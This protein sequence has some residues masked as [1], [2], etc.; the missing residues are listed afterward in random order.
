M[1]KID[2]RS[3][4][5][6]LTDVRAAPVWQF[7]VIM[8]D[9]TVERQEGTL[10]GWAAFFHIRVLCHER[11]SQKEQRYSGCKEY[12]WSIRRRFSD[13][14]ELDAALRADHI[15][16]P[17]I[18][19]PRKTLWRHLYPSQEFVEQRADELLKFM[20]S[21]LQAAAERAALEP[22][23]YIDIA[24]LSS[25]LPKFFG[26]K[27]A[28]DPKSLRPWAPPSE[29]EEKP[30][31]LVHSFDRGIFIWGHLDTG[32][33]TGTRLQKFDRQAALGDLTCTHAETMQTRTSRRRTTSIATVISETDTP[34]ASPPFMPS[35]PPTSLPPSQSPSITSSPAASLLPSPLPS[36]AGSRSATPPRARLG[37]SPSDSREETWSF[38]SESTAD[39]ETS[40]QTFREYAAPEVPRQSKKAPPAV[41]M[42]VDLDNEWLKAKEHRRWWKTVLEKHSSEVKAVRGASRIDCNSL[43]GQEAEDRQEQRRKTIA[44]Y[45][46]AAAVW[47]ELSVRHEELNTILGYGIDGKTFVVVQQ[48]APG[49]SGLRSLAFSQQSC[50]RVLGQVLQA[51]TKLHQQHLPHGHLSPESILVT[52]T[53]MGPQ[54][55]LM[56]TPSQRRPEGHASATLGF[57][58]PGIHQ[59]PAS[60]IWSLA[61][62]M[63]VWWMG[64]TPLQHPW[65]QFGHTHRLKQAIH[66]ALAE[67]PPGLPK[68]LLDLHLAAASADEPEHTFLSLLAQLLTQC[69]IW[70]PDERPT[71]E[72]LLKHRF[73]ELAL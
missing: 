18:E 66:D 41:W 56:W 48:A 35:S 23:E 64:F 65:T 62:V 19:L 25:A 40:V 52:E 10:C 44:Q 58:G 12:S 29:A 11:K 31:A 63:L 27:E 36:P 42:E 13:F 4:K 15:L 73:F 5:D 16:P 43:G 24:D 21:A 2:D 67:K 68:A 1:S 8:Q 17:S 61:C 6:K 26:M 3:M 60:D 47:R 30:A 69:L 45:E 9:H 14:Q 37:S 54:V 72:Q 51:L 33:P 22:A 39:S 49:W 7:S 50:Y 71:A 53:P 34:P 20:L 59:S 46:K 32:S 70:N 57:Q 55:R 38:T 28:D